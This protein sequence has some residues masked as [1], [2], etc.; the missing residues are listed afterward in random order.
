[1][2]MF[3]FSSPVFWVAVS[4]VIFAVLAYKPLKK[5]I[6]GGLDSK[7]EKIRNEL[8]EANR[9]KEEAHALLAQYQRQQ[10]DASIEAKEI[11]A[12][13][14]EETKIMRAEAL[15]KLEESLKRREAQAV[16]KIAQAE[17][18]AVK[19]V[20]DKAVKLA[21]AASEAILRDKVAGNKTKSAALVKDSVEQL[22]KALH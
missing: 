11:I 21:F 19:E 2:D 10:R 1:M 4:T 13:A 22:G 3:S 6:N 16:D 8:D 9:L 5:V 12:H 20:K 17:A 14:E 18:T 15:E 7:I